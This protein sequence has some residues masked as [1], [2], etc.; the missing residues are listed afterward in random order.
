[1]QCFHYNLKQNY[2]SFL[3]T[4]T[5]FGTIR[6]ASSYSYDYFLSRLIDE[7]FYTHLVKGQAHRAVE[8]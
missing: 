1:M 4:A 5:N 2:T 3:A 8:E 7:M 6:T